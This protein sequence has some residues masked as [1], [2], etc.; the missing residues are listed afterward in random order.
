MACP[1][2][3]VMG[4]AVTVSG[5][6][7]ML[8]DCVTEAALYVLLFGAEP[9]GADAMIL[10]I[11]APVVVPLAVPVDEPTVHGPD[12]TKKLTGSPELDVALT[13]NVLPY[14][15]VGN[16]PK[17]MVCG[18]VLEP[19]GVIANVPDTGVAEL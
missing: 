1:F 16:D 8:N 7:E 10:H 2:A 14:C 18:C 13:E 3:I 5:A 12:T 4:F 11:P 15:T 6:V 19:C 17:M 9:V